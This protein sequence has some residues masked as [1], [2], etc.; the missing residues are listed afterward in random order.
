M[1]K[2]LITVGVV[3]LFL[4]SCSNESLLPNDTQQG[5]ELVG[6]R[7]NRLSFDV[8]LPGGE[9]ITYAEIQTAQEKK[10]NR[11]D[12]YQFATG[13]DG[14]LEAIYNN[15]TLTPSGTGYKVTIEALG[16][17]SKQFFFVANNE[18]SN[19]GGAPS[20][21]NLTLGSITA[22]DFKKKITKELNGKQLNG[23]PLLM[24]AEVADV[25]L[26]TGDVGK[27]AE[28]T[29]VMSRLDIINYEPLLTISRVRLENCKDRNYLFAQSTGSQ[30]P[31]G[32]KV[33]ALPEAILPTAP[34]TNGAIEMEEVAATTTDIAHTHYKHVFY[35]YISD[36]VT[37]EASAPLI[38][39]EGTL[40]KGDKERETKVIYKKHLKIE[41]QADFLGFKRNTRYTLVIKK[42]VP[43]ELEA[44]VTVDKWNEETVEAKLSP[45]TPRVVNLWDPASADGYFT[46]DFNTQTISY[47]KET[48][49]KEM[50]LH[51]YANVDWEIVDEAQ[52]KVLP[53]NTY[54]VV[55]DWLMITQHNGRDYNKYTSIPYGIRFYVKSANTTGKDRSA[56]IILRNKINHNQQTVV[57][58]IQ[59]G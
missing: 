3:A 24:T 35:P 31:A 46:V 58:I 37:E 8:A 19:N 13:S 23:S 14:K 42:A 30:V 9:P 15:V 53:L 39:I 12:V 32:A 56:R 11:L 45:V 34:A 17:G 49:D 6:T 51:V 29:R 59:K 18:G 28:L 20:V 50:F 47:K 27:K 43:G 44:T 57:T 52:N 33:V 55:R 54:F 4:S 41:G 40:W 1:K 16:S 38:I 22:A 21:E 7:S 25:A 5:K 48:S 10:V 2:I 36:A 26:K